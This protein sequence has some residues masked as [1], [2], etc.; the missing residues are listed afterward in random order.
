MKNTYRGNKFG[1]RKPGN[2]KFIGGGRP[3]KPG[4]GGPRGPGGFGGELHDATCASCGKPCRVPF[5]PTGS[6]PVLCGNCFKRDGGAS[7]NPKRF[8]RSSFGE[9]PFKKFG[10]RPQQSGGPGSIEARLASIERKIDALLEALAE[11][12]DE[13][14]DED[15]K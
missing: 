7:A 11:A 5:R 6:K 14:G 15:Q 4:F 3:R 12:E 1:D 10:D 2:K 8:E 9:R 13:D